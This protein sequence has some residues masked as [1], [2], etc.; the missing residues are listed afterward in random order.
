MFNSLHVPLV[1]VLASVQKTAK[2]RGRF[3]LI[4]DKRP[5]SSC[6]LFYPFLL[7]CAPPLTILFHHCHVFH[8]ISTTISAWQ[9][10]G[11]HGQDWDLW[12]RKVQV[13]IGQSEFC[14]LIACPEHYCWLA[15]QIQSSK[16]VNLSTGIVLLPL[17]APLLE[18]HPSTLLD[19]ELN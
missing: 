3:T 12:E 16:H 7:A 9:M 15:S 13:S 11:L 18:V 6:V 5:L 8:L 19:K 17:R 14:Q 10:M 4:E 2:S 1:T